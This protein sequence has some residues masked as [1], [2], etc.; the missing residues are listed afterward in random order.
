[1]NFFLHVLFLQQ[2]GLG[3]QGIDAL[4]QFLQSG[5][6]LQRSPLSPCE[7]IRKFSPAG[8]NPLQRFD[9]IDASVNFSP[10]RRFGGPVDFSSLRRFESFG[11]PIPEQLPGISPAPCGFPEINNQ[12]NLRR[13][14]DAAGPMFSC[15]A[16]LNGQN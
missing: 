8:F 13:F 4:S 15:S 1:M 11:A 14:S 9:N 5:Q 12:N 3:G 6:F 2:C 16:P 7:G 10:V